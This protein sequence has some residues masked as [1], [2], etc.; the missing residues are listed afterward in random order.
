MIIIANL[1]RFPVSSTKL[2]HLLHQL[3]LIGDWPTSRNKAACKTGSAR[4]WT[5]NDR[6]RA[7][8]LVELSVE[9]Y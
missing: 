7:A 8:K 3:P 1:T 5:W 4:S 9:D 2:H 6:E